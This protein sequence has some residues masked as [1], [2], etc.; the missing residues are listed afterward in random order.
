MGRVQVLLVPPVSFYFKNV[1][2]NFNKLTITGNDIQEFYL[3][4]E[5]EL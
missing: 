2:K 1:F 5:E 4:E 3:V